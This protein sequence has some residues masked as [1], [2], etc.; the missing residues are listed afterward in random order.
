MRF[1]KVSFQKYSDEELM[2]KAAEGHRRAFEELYERYSAKMLGYFHRMLWKDKELAEDCLHKLF[3]NIIEKPG[4][5]DASRSFKTW[6][7]SAAHNICKNEYRRME[8]HKPDDTLQQQAPVGETLP[9]LQE[10]IFDNKQFLKALETE[11][12][13]L[14]ENHRETFRLRYFEQLSLK[15]IAAVMECSEGTVKSRLFYSIKTLSEKLKPFKSL[16]TP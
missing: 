1:I 5:F 2:Q 10:N 11:L 3:L 8:R 15:E 4:L 6:L 13:E 16:L 12:E 7:Y 9:P 14:G